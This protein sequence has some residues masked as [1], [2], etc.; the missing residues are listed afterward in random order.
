MEEITLVDPK[1]SKN[2]KPLKEVAPISI[3]PN[4]PDCYVMIRT[5]LIEELRSILVK[6]LKR[7]YDIFA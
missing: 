2:I 6:F 4:Y 5:E 3:H 7:N 1:K